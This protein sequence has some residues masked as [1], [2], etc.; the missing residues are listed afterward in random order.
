MWLFG[1]KVTDDGAA[2]LANGL[3][4]GELRFHSGGALLGVS[5]QNIPGR[6]DVTSVQAE[7]AAEKAGVETG[8]IIVEYGGVPIN[9]F[10]QL[11]QLIGVDSPGKETSLTV[12]RAGEKKVITLT[13]G[14]W[15]VDAP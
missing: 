4:F 5:C 14:E 3:T 12:L 7:T 6:C 1:T 10:D 15:D 9:S 13:L 11:R 8:D 2:R